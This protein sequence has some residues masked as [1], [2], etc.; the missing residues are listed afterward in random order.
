MKTKK[1]ILGV[2][3]SVLGILACIFALLKNFTVYSVI[4]NSTNQSNEFWGFFSE[5]ENVET[6]F[7]GQDKEYAP[8]FKTIAGIIAIVLAIA[9]VAYIVL[10]V[11]DLKKGT[12]F[13]GLRKIIAIVM[14]AAAV[15]MAA[16]LLIYCLGN[17]ITA[18]SNA[19][20]FTM[21]TFPAIVLT[22]C[23]LAAG[24]CAFAAEKD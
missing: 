20:V 17:K 22:V 7:F 9:V 2:L 24:V 4:G 14:A 13:S 3:S 1:L 23:P 6:L 10:L 15:L 8:A 11:L 19:I 21:K 12:K 5:L 18:G 16:C